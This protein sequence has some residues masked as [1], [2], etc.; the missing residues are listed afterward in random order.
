MQPFT[1][2]F[3]L[4]TP[5]GVV[6]AFHLP[7]SSAPVDPAVLAELAPEEA[8][9]AATLGGYV[10][11]SFVGGRLALRA[12]R[13]LVGAPLDAVLPDP[14]GTPVLGRGWVGSVSHKRTL[15]VAMVAR[16]VEG[17]LGVDLEDLLPERRN[18]TDKVLRPEEV[19]EVEALPDQLIWNATVLR[20]SMKESIYKALDPYVRR[21]V[22]FHEATVRPSLEGTAQITLHLA[23]G[24][25]PFVVDG[26]FQWLEGRVLTSVR[27]RRA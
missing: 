22:G 6:A 7:D 19:A 2:A 16:D 18:V 21:Y 1:P 10:Q 8:A 3:H 13:R 12:A 24:E 20:F 5:H 14:R 23:Q 4:G 9:H 17:T 27:I 26:R 11:V 15:A 25:G